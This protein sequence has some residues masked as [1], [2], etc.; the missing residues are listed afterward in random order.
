[1]A[2]RSASRN[3][4]SARVAQ[5]QPGQVIGLR[6]SSIVSL[7]A[8]GQLDADQVSAAMHFRDDWQII[9]AGSSPERLFDRVDHTPGAGAAER[10]ADAKQR[11]KR[12]RALVGAHGFDL[13]IKICG[14]GWHIRDLYRER[15]ERDTAADMLRIHLTELAC[16][17]IRD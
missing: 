7:A 2:Q 10:I 6:D 14:D 8:H 16:A 1:M 9:R 15:R 11:L 4:D 5:R 3:V 17:R 13:L 12:C